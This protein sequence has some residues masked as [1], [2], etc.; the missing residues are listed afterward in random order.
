MRLFEILLLLFN[1]VTLL[2]LNLPFRPRPGWFKFLP[3]ITLGAA[4]LHLLVEQAR[5]QMA[6]AYLL[7]A[8][9][10]LLSLPELFN[11]TLPGNRIFA[12]LGSGLALLCWAA[13][14]ALSTLLPVPRLPT[15]P[16]PDAIGTLTFDWLD[17]AR[18]E[19]YSADP[20]DKRRIMVQIWYPA[21]PTAGAQTA[22]VIA[23]W[24]LVG[25]VIADY[26]G[27]PAFAVE[28]LS[29]VRTH[30]VAGT[31]LKTSSE[32]YPV[33]IYSH[34][35]TSYRTASFSQ[36][37]A[38]AS[39]G[40][41]VVAIDHPY[42]AMFSVFSDRR[43]L[44]NNSAVVLPPGDA[45]ARQTLE[46][47][48]AADVRF[49][50]DQL[51]ALNS[52]AFDDRFSGMLDLQRIGL[53]GVSTGGG[54]IVWVCSLDPRCQA[55]AA[56]DGWFEPLPAALI[57][58]PLRQPFLF[59]QS[60]TQMWNFDNQPRLE[61]LYQN[62]AA[63][64]YHLKITGALHRDFGDYP[65]ITPLSQLLPE[66][67]P[68]DGARTVEIVNTYVLAFFDSYLKNQ[69]APLLSGPLPEMPEAQFQSHSP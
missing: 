4:L 19:A 11:K 56:L 34:G 10:F 53:A 59:M 40:Y 62:A 65:L 2:L 25:P 42:S 3:A 24:D 30:S 47:T 54:A 15:P 27:L 41:I 12:I 17:P 61:S 39:S 1:L 43:M 35:Y 29:L 28:H 32:P 66:R 36:A 69:P 48:H 31:P 16:G 45:Q 38:L 7:T 46:A 23:D 60:E 6:P 8:V 67:G 13:A 49:V 33:V 64:A 68:L 55:G 50:M 52:G 9:L 22:P 26:L 37:E 51:E 44:L 63:D 14:L 20:A 57:A 5:W 21:Q 18:A 58:E